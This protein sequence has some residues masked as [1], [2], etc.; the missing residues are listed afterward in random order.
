MPR[1]FITLA[2][3]LLSL[4]GFSQSTL[5]SL[6]GY[7]HNWNDANAPYIQPDQVDARYNIIEV[8]FAI[9]TSP[10]N[11][12]MVFVPDVISQSSFITKVQTLQ[13]QGRKVLISIGGATSNIDLTTTASK[14]AFVS[15]MTGI[16]N[17]YGFDGMDIDIESGASI[18]ISG[19]TIAAPGSVAQQNLIA[20]IKEIMA[21]YHTAHAKKFMLTMAPE[22]AYVQGGQTGFGN[23]WG[24]Y[25]PIIHALGDSLDILQ[26]Q[27]YN[28]GTMYGIDGNI[29]TQ[30][31]AD[32]IVAMTEAVIHGF[33]TTTGGFFT[34]LPANKVAVGLPACNLAAGGG[35]TDTAIVRSAMKYL[36]GTGT[37]P[38]TY[39]LV[40]T[41]GYPTLRGMMTWSINWDAV[42]SCNGAYSYAV[43]YQNIFGATTSTGP[44]NRPEDKLLISPNPA[45]NTL[46]IECPEGQNLNMI[47]FNHIGEQVIQ[48]YLTGSK[49]AIDISALPSGMYI[50]KVM[51][52]D[53][54]E[55]RKLIKE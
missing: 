8:A 33:N 12:T 7:L 53:W 26:V 13:A 31:T 4:S 3:L 21:A 49:Q 16:I 1:P 41:G 45:L 48:R 47:M 15:S 35:Y 32:F 54:T 30:G 24:G 23:I 11:M 43:N 9:P 22:T 27:L 5:H 36:L 2:F 42:A 44:L 6:V 38:G 14:N 17:T 51:G 37:K 52:G 25:L 40:N 39:T 28:T 50:V 20:A 34:G 55:Q 19:G 18:L 10:T 46:N 29:Y